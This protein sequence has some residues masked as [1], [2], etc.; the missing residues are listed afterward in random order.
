M[1]IDTKEIQ[2]I[3]NLFEPLFILFTNS[4]KDDKTLS[5][6][7]KNAILF[8]TVMDLIDAATARIE[9][10]N[11]LTDTEVTEVKTTLFNA[12]TEKW[13]E[14]QPALIIDDDL[15]AFYNKL[16]THQQQ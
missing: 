12:L 4:V 11:N 10:N 16:N 9:S 15:I 6:T 7:E 1:E 14:L 2:S 5:V 13:K 3:Q 8:K